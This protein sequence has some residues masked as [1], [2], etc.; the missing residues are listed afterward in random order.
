[1]RGGE[2]MIKVG[3]PPVIKE[4]PVPKSPKN[5]E[6][7]EVFYQMIIEYHEL[8]KIKEAEETKRLKIKEETEL[9]L[10]ALDTFEKLA[11]DI[12]EKEFNEREVVLKTIIEKLEN[13]ENIEEINLYLRVIV[14]I[15]NLDFLKKNLEG[16]NLDFLNSN[17]SEKEGENEKT[18]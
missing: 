12:I 14:E 10:K 5:V 4:I 2:N 6:Y 15:L 16:I 9:K 8:E 18:G 3:K 7:V 11:S 1:V 13:T 17:K